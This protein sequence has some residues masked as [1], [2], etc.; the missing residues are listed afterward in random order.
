[1]TLL[2]QR[3][4]FYGLLVRLSALLRLRVQLD[5]VVNAKDGDRCLSC[6]L[7]TLCLNHGGLVHASL[8]VVSWL[9]VH[10]VQTNPAGHKGGQM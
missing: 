10:Q 8:T 3:S 5:E 7:K 6:K 2:I 1:M 9:T 4:R